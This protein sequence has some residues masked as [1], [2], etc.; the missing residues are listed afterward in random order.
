MVVL[1][2]FFVLLC[3]SL[4]GNSLSAGRT[5]CADGMLGE[6]AHRD[7]RARAMVPARSWY[8]ARPDQVSAGRDQHSGTLKVGQDVFGD[9]YRFGT[10]LC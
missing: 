3:S 8:A 9:P 1:Q 5:Q 4:S 6:C 7:I 2:F 10:A